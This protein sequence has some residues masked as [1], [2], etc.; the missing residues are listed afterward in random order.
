MKQHLECVVQVP[1]IE[2][3]WTTLCP[4]FG[5]DAGKTAVIVR[6]LCGL[7]SAGAAFRIHL[8]KCMDS[9]GYKSCKTDPDLWLKPE[10]K[11]EDGVQYYYYLLCYVGDILC[12]H[13]NT[14]NMLEQLHKSFPLKLEFGTQW[15]MG[16]GNESC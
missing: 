1:V 13:H 5:K 9:L 15:S 6:A 10:I 11:P 4:D 3:V 12:I 16:I 14:D 7:K 8:A 2:K